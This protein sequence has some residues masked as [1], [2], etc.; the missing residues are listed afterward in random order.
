M[1]SVIF[2]I[3]DI[4]CE[5]ATWKEDICTE[6]KGTNILLKFAA[7]RI[8]CFAASLQMAGTVRTY[9]TSWAFREIPCCSIDLKKSCFSAKIHFPNTN[10]AGNC[11]PVSS[12]R[13]R[14]GVIF[15]LI[16]NIFWCS[17]FAIY[18]VSHYKGAEALGNK[19]SPKLS[20]LL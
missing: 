9:L 17:T 10:W 2:Y 18:D 3:H 4:C 6:E 7:C 13:W 16:G 1:L 19:Y 8:N 14:S 15:C 12:V 5:R 11:F 20:S